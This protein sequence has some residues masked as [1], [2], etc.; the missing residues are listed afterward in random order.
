MKYRVGGYVKLAKL[1]EKRKDEAIPYHKE[2]YRQK[3]ESSNRYALEDV[4]IDITGNKQILKRPEMIRLIKDCK[5]GRIDC[6]A[7]QTKAYLAADAR[8]FC[9]LLKILWSFD[10][11][12]HIITEDEDYNINTVADI[13]N[14]VKEL[15]RMADKYIS[16]NPTDF[17]EWKDKILKA[18]E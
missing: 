10:F 7:T 17:S 14:Q 6:I 12:V 9:Y 15:K 13:E 18:I 11:M 1:W 3:Y 5:N 16:L 2:Y 4:Y 8:E